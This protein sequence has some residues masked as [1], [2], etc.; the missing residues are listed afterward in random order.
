ME[1]SDFLFNMIPVILLELVAAITGV[2]YLRNTNA[3]FA[4]KAFVLFLW[5]TVVV[6]LVGTY[7]GIGYFTN[8]E[9]FGLVKDTPFRNNYWLYNIYQLLSYIFYVYFLSSWM[10]NKK[11]RKFL[12]VLSIVLIVSVVFDFATND[13]FNTN[14]RV[15]TIFGSLLVLLAVF[16]FYLDL[17]NSNKPIAFKYYLPAYI[18]I[19]ILF[20]T[21]CFSPL[22][23][24]SNYFKTSTGNQL[25]VSF[26]VY[27]LFILNILLYL[28]YTFAFIICSKKKK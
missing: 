18:S 4:E 16:F 3:R 26:R 13:F 5:L 19:A 24:L 17:L 6:E 23:F 14:S 25:F 7:A 22:D 28:T 15:S 11:L 10:L 27:T 21:L 9:Y 2:Y 8:Y 20:H 1:F 12:L